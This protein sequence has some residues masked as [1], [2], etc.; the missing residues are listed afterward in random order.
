MANL[1]QTKREAPAAFVSRAKALYRKHCAANVSDGAL[2]TDEALIF[3]LIRGL[4]DR[5]LVAF[6]V[7]KKVETVTHLREII[8]FYYHCVKTDKWKPVNILQK[9]WGPFTNYVTQFRWVGGS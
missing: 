6:L 1:R 7:D 2:D 4:F 3:N 5:Q 9:G 8:D